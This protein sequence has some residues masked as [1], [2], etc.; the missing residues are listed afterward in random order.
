MSTANDLLHLHL[1]TYTILSEVYFQPCWMQYLQSIPLKITQSAC[2]SCHTLL[3]NSAV[4]CPSTCPLPPLQGHLFCI[5]TLSYK[6]FDHRKKAAV[7]ADE[8]GHSSNTLLAWWNDSTPLVS[9]LSLHK[10]AILVEKYGAAWSIQEPF[11]T[12]SQVHLGK[13]KR[14]G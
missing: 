1:Y 13:W 12:T 2:L 5:K 8:K 7:A 3:I 14:S 4:I 10:P 11:V 6:R 9:P